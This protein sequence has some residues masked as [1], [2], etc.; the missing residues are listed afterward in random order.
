MKLPILIVFILTFFHFAFAQAEVEKKTGS[1]T[2]EVTGLENDD[3]EV[4]IAV[5]NSKE[6]YE[7]DNLAFVGATAKIE[8]GQAEYTSTEYKLETSLKLRRLYY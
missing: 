7:S 5:S 6:N 8:N 4:L 2:I 3:G 1:I